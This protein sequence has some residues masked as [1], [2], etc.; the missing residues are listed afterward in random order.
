MGYEF[1]QQNLPEKETDPHLQEKVE[2][3]IDWY[4]NTFKLWDEI[5]AG[6]TPELPTDSEEAQ[7]YIDKFLYLKEHNQEKYRDREGIE[8]YKRLDEY[9]EKL[10]TVK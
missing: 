2:K 1:P 8:F 3:A 6:T 7:S 9:I 5:S 4:K 10:K